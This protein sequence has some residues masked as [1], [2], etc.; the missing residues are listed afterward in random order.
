MYVLDLGS[1]WIDHPFLRNHFLVKNDAQLA[2]LRSLSV[3]EIHIDTTKGADVARLAPSVRERS[4]PVPPAAPDLATRTRREQQADLGTEKPRA[5]RIRQ[6]ATQLVSGLMEDLRLGRQL[7]IERVNPVVD[8]MIGSIFRN[9]D[10]LVGLTRIRRMDRYT[11]EHSVSVAVLMIAFGRFQGLEKAQVHE[12]GVGA[13]LHDV[14]KILVPGEILNKPGRLTDAEFQVMRGHVNHGREVLWGAAGISPLALSVALEH[15]E[16]VNGKGYPAGLSADRISAHGKMAAI[17]DVYDAMTSDRVYHKGMPP[18]LA[19]RHLL[20]GAGSDF[21]AE[22]T[23]RFIQCVGIYPLGSV[24]R[25]AS[26]RIGVVVEANA[27]EPLAPVVRV[28]LDAKTRRFLTPR[29][30]D[31]AHQSGDS[32]D[33]ILGAEAAAPWRIRPE[34]YLEQPR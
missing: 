20:A 1:G 30:L 21:D 26:G 33:R 12:L 7:E 9:K 22:L 29:T 11:F 8:R 34:V 5:A 27:E 15:H 13:L 28:V 16:R 25:L 6:E 10:A 24:V 17:V 32:A 19:L 3:R 18:Y 23:Q 4:V 31:L 2:K 14:G